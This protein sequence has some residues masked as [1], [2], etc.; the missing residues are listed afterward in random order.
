MS[1]PTS[2]NELN[3]YA[4]ATIAAT[5][6]IIFSDAS[7]SDTIKRANA[8]SIQSIIDSLLAHSVTGTL[9]MTGEIIDNVLKIQTP[10]STSIFD[11][12]NLG[13]SERVGWALSGVNRVDA[14]F[15][16]SGGTNYVD[17]E[18]VTLTVG[19][20][21]TGFTGTVT[22]SGGAV[23]SVQILDG[24][25][26]YASSESATID[27]A[28]SSDAS[29]GLVVS[30]NYS[31][32]LDGNDVLQFVDNSS[33]NSIRFHLPQGRI[34]ARNAAGTL[35]LAV[36]DAPGI[37]IL[38][39]TVNDF[40]FQGLDIVNADISA[41]SNTITMALDDLSDVTIT[42]AA[43]AQF[44][45]Y[46]G[47]GTI[48]ENKTMSG[49]ATL[50]SDGTLTI[51]S[52]F[53]TSADNLS[54]FS[55]TTSAQLRGV[56]SDETGTGLLVFNTNS[57]LTTPFIGNFTNATHDH[58]DP[59]GGEQLDITQASNA[60]GT[61]DGTTFL[62]GDNTWA[63]A[64][65]GI[66]DM[67]LAAVQTVT[68]AKTFGTVGGAVD[69]FLLAGSTSGTTILNAA[70]VAGTTT[71]TLQGVTGTVALLGDKL[72]A[73]ATT[74]SAELAS[75]ISNTTGTASLVFSGTPSL[76]NPIISVF[77][78][79]NHDHQD[80][81][82]GGKLDSTLALSDTA[83]IAYLNTANAWSTGLQNFS[84]AT[85]RIPVS[86]TPT[87][88]V[89]GDIAYDD[90]VTDFTTGLIRFFGTEEQGI[91]SMPIAQFTTPTDGFVVSYNG[92]NDEFELVAAGTGDMVLANVQTVTGA[93]TFGTVGGAV[94]KF[95]LAGSTSGTTILNAAAVAGAGT[96]VLPTTGTLAT[97][98]GSETLTN[99]TID[100][101]NN[102][103][104]N[105]VI[106]AEVTGASTAL[107]DTADI[108]YLNTANAYTSNDLQNF[109]LSVMRV[110]F[111]SG[112]TISTNGDFG[113]NPDL[114]TNWSIGFLSYFSNEVMA[115]VGMPIAQF[116]TPTD[117]DVVTYNGTSEEFELV[118]AS[119]GAT[120][121][122]ELTDVTITD[123]A[124]G[125]LLIFG[126]AQTAF[127]IAMQGDATIIANGTITIAA[128][129]VTY[130]KMQNV[131]S[132]DVILG[133]IAGAGG[134][135]TELTGTQ[136][137]VLLDTFTDSLQGVAPASGGGTTNFLRADGTWAVPAGG[138]GEFTDAW[139]ANH[140]QGGSAFSLEDARFAD[141]T[142]DSKTIQLDLTGMTTSIE[143]TITSIQSTAQTLTIPNIT[144]ADVL[145]T[146]NLTQTI[147]N[148]TIDADN[149]TISNLVIGA[150]VTGASTSLTDTADIAYLNTANA[151]STGLQNFSAATLRIPV[152][153]TPTVAVDGDIAYDDTVTDFTTG[154]IRFFGTEEQGIVSMP[155]AQFTTPTDGFVVSYNGTNDEFELV[156][157]GTGDMVLANVQTVTG[158]KTFGTVGGAVDK[159]LLAGSTSGTTILNAAAVAGAGTVVLPTTGTLATLAGSETLTN[160]T[161]D[162]DN[163]T[164]SN[165]VI[166]AEVT[167]ASTSLTDT[168]DIAYLNTANTYGDGF[169]QTFNPDATNAGLNMGSQVD[170]DPTAPVNGDI[171]Y[172]STNNKFRAYENG[173][174]TDMIGG[175]SSPLTTKGDIYT[176]TT[177]DARLGVGTDGQVLSANSVETTGLE[178]IDATG[179]GTIT[180]S[181]TTA[182]NQI[183]RWDGA[184]TTIIQ[185]SAVTLDDTPSILQTNSTG[186]MLHTFDI[187]TIVVDDTTIGTISFTGLDDGSSPVTYASIASTILSDEAG[188][189]MGSLSL[190]V[191]EAG[192][193]ASFIT[194]DGGSSSVDFVLPSSA[195]EITFTYNVTEEYTF[196]NS[197]LDVHSNFIN[198]IE[199]LILDAIADPGTPINDQGYLF[200][201]DDNG[202]SHLFFNN[203]S[204]DDFSTHAV[205]LT[206]FT[207]IQFV[208]DGGGSAITTGIKG[209]LEIPFKCE[210][211]AVRLFAD[212]A[213]TAVIDI[214]SDSF[215]N[216][217]PL[218]G[219][220]ITASAQPSLSASDKSEDTTLTGW[221]TSIPQGNTLRYNVDSNDVAE[222]ITVSLTVI[223]T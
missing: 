146:E 133:N 190:S 60:T 49:D 126:A 7:D 106:G 176:F 77:T 122:D 175:G 20:G 35:Q 76:S 25:S 117:G 132:D 131:T 109:S 216:Y 40:D 37:I 213:A 197:G 43:A 158:A 141:P 65:A 193:L 129:A 112:I 182:D 201:N 200:V 157:A 59:A 172:N 222:R 161:I 120:S 85:L 56:I 47:G 100:A 119:G 90:T 128:D 92:T 159:F 78:N 202:P 84:A 152:S 187:D 23:V 42:S 14:F 11:G 2:S 75:V 86:A 211:I 217:P 4:T 205:N 183:T 208:I 130:A 203:P 87:V 151:W 142:D 104:S 31:F 107:S 118:A 105:L 41:A 145:V 50:A 223:K 81:A 209:D 108:A 181:G 138:G 116:T 124:S 143:L 212:Q 110:P 111:G 149:N 73:F 210:I 214:W 136:V 189:E 1:A 101:D 195:G 98:A 196:S 154:L 88:A 127:D 147:I 173:V 221:T 168:A 10:T 51:A 91:V 8:Q 64:G 96:V 191:A 63:G 55:S 83:D 177:V 153:A 174:W 113:V 94:D 186:S 207:S 115:A 179:T 219:D 52:N 198:N 164:I 150:E 9:D 48:M 114:N 180:K 67:I 99:K 170:P 199:F 82:G 16:I 30:T 184:D 3:D 26:G 220:S 140:N 34:H 123:G 163:N 58:Q 72:D 148:K 15:N 45:I 44:L 61:P 46:N 71:V 165:L 19:S 103:I 93:K 215:A 69:K 80:P 79:A 192:T 121:L 137:T 218:V 24:G 32:I 6:Q 5:D 70:A 54:F 156:A 18:S 178:W 57:L 102:T 206:A 39:A 162:A 171:Y 167:G 53:A 155:I 27:G 22:V 188:D 135:V 125:K 139:T 21:G 62:R 134:I 68:G 36:G 144:A 13:N 160:K 169:K 74:T 204:G 33:T 95:L 29:G 185:G 38:E 28:S 12:L 66:G 97:L 194:L 89:D 17:G 166:G